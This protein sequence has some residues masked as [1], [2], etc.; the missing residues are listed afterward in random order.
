MTARMADDA[1]YGLP[2]ISKA[3]EIKTI[4]CLLPQLASFDMNIRSHTMARQFENAFL[5]SIT[6][7]P[8]E[9]GPL[10]SN[11]YQKPA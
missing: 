8:R 2:L 7:M 11:V 3:T 10:L 6:A 5:R 4:F 1:S 9:A